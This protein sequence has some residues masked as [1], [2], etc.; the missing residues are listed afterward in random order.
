MK[1][2]M[3]IED[4]EV[5]LV[6]GVLEGALGVLEVSLVDGV[7]EGALGALGLEMEA[8]VWAMECVW[9]LMMSEGDGELVLCIWREFMG[10]DLFENGMNLD[11][12]REFENVVQAFWVK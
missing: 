3:S 11:K 6:D 10:R 8:Y 1:S 12:F 5:S 4:E 2:D 7:L 9:L